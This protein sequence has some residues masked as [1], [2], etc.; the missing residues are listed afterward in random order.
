VNHNDVPPAD[1]KLVEDAPRS[2]PVC[3][4]KPRFA[5]AVVAVRSDQVRLSDGETVTRDVIEHPGAV[6]VIA[7]DAEARVLLVR[8]YRHCVGRMLWEPPAGLLDVAGEPPLVAAQRELFEE[9]GYRAQSWAV[10][11]DAFTSPGCSDEAMRIYLA[12]E[13]AAVPPSERH[14]GEH[15]EAGMPVRW[16]GLDD[17]VDQVLAGRL[18]NPTAVMG[19]LAT[20][21]ARDAGWAG[22]RAA[23]APWAERPVSGRKD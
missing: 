9:A 8:Q 1:S 21:R 10:L 6:G 12:R 7:L 19:L 17:A 5:G 22:L 20:T 4:S 15:E 16:L 18:H 2:Y 11:V 13:L 23:D 14:A 3:G